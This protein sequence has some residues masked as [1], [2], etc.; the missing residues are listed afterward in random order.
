MATIDIS[1]ELLQEYGLPHW[2]QNGVQIVE[3]KIID[4]SRWSIHHSLIFKWLDGKFYETSYRVGATE[5][6]DE[7][8]WEYDETIPCTEVAQVEKVVKVWE[9][10]P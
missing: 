8:A 6:Q 10:V 9:P 5:S 2:G 1:K 4:N 3:D 7:Q